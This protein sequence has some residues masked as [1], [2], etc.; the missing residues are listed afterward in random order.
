MTRP[1]LLVVDDDPESCEVL[2][3]ALQAE[4]YEVAT[5]PG[6][7]AALHLANERVFDVVIS[8]IRMPDLDGMALLR[9]LRDAA[10]DLSVILLTAFGTVEA[11][12]E[13]IKA[14]AFD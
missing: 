5:A 7:Q 6:G 12:L 10:P 13:A 2:A 3:E 4:G 14:G 8:D 11:A 1:R 9:G